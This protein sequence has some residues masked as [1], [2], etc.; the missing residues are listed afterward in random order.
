MKITATIF[1]LAFCS[2]LSLSA[3]DEPKK[4]GG[5]P[6]KDGDKPRANPE[7]IFKKLDGNGDGFLSKEEF[8]AGPRAKADPA[9]AEAHY[10]ELDKAGD[11]KV[12]L[13]EF[14]AGMHHEKKAK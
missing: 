4:D 5:K 10:K 9:K 13:E 2:A 14:K 11:G 3:A 12:T 1:A 7:E 8:L 6:H